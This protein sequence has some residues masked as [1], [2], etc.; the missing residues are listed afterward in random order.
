MGIDNSFYTHT[1]ETPYPNKTYIL[2][3]KYYHLGKDYIP[4]NLEN[5]SEDYSRSGM[6]L[7]K[8]AKEAFEE[9]SKAS[10]E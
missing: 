2:V 10:I 3:N 8:E 9:L 6:K 4:D 5:I 7:V 1:K